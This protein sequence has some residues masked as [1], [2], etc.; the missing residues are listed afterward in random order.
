MTMTGDDP[1]LEISRFGRAVYALSLV[2]ARAIVG[3]IALIICLLIRLLVGNSSLPT[4]KAEHAA[5][6]DSGRGKDYAYYDQD[7]QANAGQCAEQAKEETASCAPGIGLLAAPRE[8]FNESM[9]A[10]VAVV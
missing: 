1:C 5:E 2:V 7:Y 10:M 9:A 4:T 3:R 8:L 6:Y